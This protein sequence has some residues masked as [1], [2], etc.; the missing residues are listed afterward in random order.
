MLA[1]PS[2]NNRVQNPILQ[3]DEAISWKPT[4]SHLA[5][6]LWFCVECIHSLFGLPS[7]WVHLEQAI[8]P[9][10]THI[11]NIV[12]PCPFSAGIE[13][14]PTSRSFHHRRTILY[15]AENARPFPSTLWCQAPSRCPSR[16]SSLWT[17][18]PVL[19][20]PQ[21]LSVSPIY[22]AHFR[23]GLCTSFIQPQTTGSPRTYVH[24]ARSFRL[25]LRIA[26]PLVGKSDKVPAVP[27]ASTA[28][29]CQ[30]LPHH[31]FSPGMLGIWRSRSLTTWFLGW[32]FPNST[33]RAAELSVEEGLTYHLEISWSFPWEGQSLR[34]N[35]E[36]GWRHMSS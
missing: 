27:S 20:P 30:L 11:P 7:P 29:A 15:P 9:R 22:P 35:R 24:T 10:H 2:L 6:F 31:L 19:W 17:Q 3:W 23:Q 13:A 12:S 8:G 36:H 16:L 1:W 34:V 21:V 28:P 26:L 14:C 32:P 25:L 18:F 4:V 33:S 5:W